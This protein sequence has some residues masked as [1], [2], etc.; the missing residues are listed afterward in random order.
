[1]LIRT[2]T[3]EKPPW[4]GPCKDC[5]VIPEVAW[6]AGLF[7]GEGTITRSGK[8]PRLCLAMHDESVVRRFAAAMGIGHVYGPYR[9]EGSLGG[10]RDRWHWVAQG[11]ERARDAYLLLRPWL[12]DRRKAQ[13]V[14]IFGEIT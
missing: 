9:N 11:E 13:G 5:L 8:Q 2:T 6:A 14:A 12:S 7:E 3:D 4:P 10:I 1:V